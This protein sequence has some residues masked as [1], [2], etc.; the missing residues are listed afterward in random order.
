MDR[1][2][3]IVCECLFFGSLAFLGL[4]IAVGIG[5]GASCWAYCLWRREARWWEL[6][7]MV[8]L[9]VLFWPALLPRSRR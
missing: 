6:L 2:V 8:V 3:S 5:L 4:Y 7:P 1:I 9:A